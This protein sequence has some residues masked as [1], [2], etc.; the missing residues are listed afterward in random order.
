MQSGEELVISITAIRD[1]TRV[2]VPIPET[3]TYLAKIQP[4]SREMWIS[5]SKTTA[6]GSSLAK[7]LAKNRLWPDWAIA[8]VTAGEVSGKLAEVLD[9]VRSFMIDQKQVMG[10]VKVKVLTPLA[11]IGGGI[12]MFIGFMIGV[13]PGI[14]K[15]IPENKRTGLVLVSDFFS[16]LYQN[17]LIATCAG[18]LI[19]LLAAWHFFRQD[20]VKAALYKV[21]DSIPGIGDGMRAIYLGFWA[22]FMAMLDDAGDVAFSDMVLIAASLTP[23]LYHPSFRAMVKEAEK[24]GLT[25]A[26]DDSRFSSSDPRKKWPLRLTVG[27]QIAAKTGEIGGPLG[28]MAP[29]IVED[30]K[31]TVTKALAPFS[32]LAT[33]LA[34]AGIV[35]PFVGLMLL[36]LKMAQSLQ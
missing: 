26:V 6:A 22:R 33:A 19:F 4:K 1:F 7:A 8:A 20:A 18:F 12:A 27:L 23:R 35:A 31:A 15:S 30:G 3:C 13:Y 32:A 34:A 17:H 24:V 2:G 16:N 5:I 9:K 36:Q 11:Y 29:D 10:V 25:Q 21:V 14:T 28:S